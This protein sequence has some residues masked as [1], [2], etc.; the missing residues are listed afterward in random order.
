MIQDVDNTLQALLVQKVPIDLTAIDIKFEIP[1]KEWSATV[2]RP[3]SSLVA[4]HQCM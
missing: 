3:K 1:T 4:P 2:T